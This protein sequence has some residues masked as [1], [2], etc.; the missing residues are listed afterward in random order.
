MPLVCLLPRAGSLRR[1]PLLLG[2]IALGLSLGVPSPAVAA[3]ARLIGSPLA[4]FARYPESGHPVFQTY[5]QLTRRIPRK[6]SGSLLGAMRLNGL[7]LETPPSADSYSSFGFRAVT[8]RRGRYCYA[9]S[10]A[11]FGYNEYPPSLQQ[12]KIG[13][14][15]RVE[16][17]IHGRTKPLAGSTRLRGSRSLTEDVAARRLGCYGPSRAK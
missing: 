17:L 7:G 2:G 4:S 5:V 1:V 15:V 12:A 8:E 13:D 9:Q 3:E 16:V 10:F 6:P 14:K 11:V